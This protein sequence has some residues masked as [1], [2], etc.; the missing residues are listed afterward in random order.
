[1]KKR[2]EESEASRDAY[3][4]DGTGPVDLEI[5][6]LERSLAPLRYRPAKRRRAW[7]FFAA[8]SV[9]AIAA[10]LIAVIPQQAVSSW[11]VADG[12]AAAPLRSGQVIATD[13]ATPVRLHSPE[14]GNVTVEPNSRLRLLRPSPTQERFSLEFGTLRAFIWAPPAKFAVKT[15]SAM[16]TD[17]GCVYTLQTDRRGEGKLTVEIGWVALESGDTESFIPAGA[18]CRIH[19]HAGPGLPVYDDAEPRFQ[20]QVYAI[21]TSQAAPLAETLALARP[22]DALTLWHLI[23]RARQ[24]ERRQVVLRF[25]D[26]VELPPDLLME[27]LVNA[28]PRAMDTAWSALRLGSTEWWRNWKQVW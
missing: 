21:G 6:A 13:A 27:D 19:E 17:L 11:S 9:A 22:K 12:G 25:A 8:A 26:L 1:M 23:L 28:Q 15:P 2:F 16:A 5:A 20:R 10:L 7:I 18:H 4:W 3:L 24:T 14:F